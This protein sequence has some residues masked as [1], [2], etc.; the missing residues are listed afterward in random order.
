M[1]SLRSATK[2]RWLS[3]S[4]IGQGLL[5]ACDIRNSYPGDLSMKR[6]LV[7][8]LALIFFAVH[9]S[10]AYCESAPYQ[11]EMYR[12]KDGKIKEMRDDFSLGEKIYADFSFLP[13]EKETGVEF[14]WINPQN[15]KEQAYFEL[16][17]S[18]MPPQKKTVLCWLVLYPSLPEK[19][20]GSRFFGRWRLEIRVNNR[21][22][23]EKVFDVG[24]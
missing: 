18:P 7:Q 14:R 11:I 8:T 16:V 13:E 19:I 17:K 9:V 12:L 23:A 2:D 10:A 20:I 15:K 4:G 24:N 1:R 6:F 21:R 22:V 5:K 3:D